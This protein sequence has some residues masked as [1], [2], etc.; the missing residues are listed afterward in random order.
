MMT[1]A[2]CVG[3]VDGSQSAGQCWSGLCTSDVVCGD[4]RLVHANGVMDNDADSA[5]VVLKGIEAGELQSDA[6]RALY[7]LLYT[8]GQ[9]KTMDSIANDSLINVALEYYK[10][11]R[12]RSLY[13][14]ALIYKGAVMQELGNDAEAMM[15]YKHA[16]ANASDD[17]YMNLGQANLR[18]SV[19]YSLN[20][21]DSREIIAKERKALDYYRKAGNKSY[22]LMCLGGLGGEYR[23]VD[24]DS[25]Y[26]YLNEA[27]ELAKKLRN[28]YRV[29]SYTEMLARALVFDS[30]Y[31]EA[32]DIA[33]PYINSRCEYIDNDIYYDAAMA[34][35]HLGMA[36]SAEYYLDKTLTPKNEAEEV[37]QL[38]VKEVIS[39][40]KKEYNEAYRYNIKA[41]KLSECV[42]GNNKLGEIEEQVKHLAT[43]KYILQN[44]DLREDLTTHI[45]MVVCLIVLLIIIVCAVYKKWQHHKREIADYE[46]LVTRYNEEL[47]QKESYI[48][49]EQN[50]E[51]QIIAKYNI[52]ILNEIKTCV[53]NFAS[54]PEYFVKRLKSIQ[55]DLQKEN[56]NF[57][58]HLYKITNESNDNILIKIQSDYAVLS[59]EDIR[60][61]SMM[62]LN[63]GAN[64][65]SF[66]MGF[67]NDK[68]IYQRK[69]RIAQKMNLQISLDEF[70]Q[71]NRQKNSLLT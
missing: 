12:N 42:V 21:A 64:T 48:E 68:S 3:S 44:K 52:K 69:K 23:L 14:R 4:A 25:A 28:N 71:E 10:D 16:E 32:K 67:S 51:L 57:W 36:D 8:Q 55:E 34:Y 7:A 33:V 5:M 43:E 70:V 56:N 19:L 24:M 37:K 6:D 47:K 46:N 18:M 61:I 17:D 59:D 15:W 66:C 40:A 2:G 9:Y 53:I 20:Y 54:N 63:F 60:I 65:I 11:N 27:I 41:N 49:A 13:T 1:L 30:L 29:Y 45:V 22:E 58:K 35:A 26:K 38:H 50:W 31:A 62:F 39:V